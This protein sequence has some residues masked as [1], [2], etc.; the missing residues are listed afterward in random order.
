MVTLAN[1]LYE[2]YNPAS[3][4]IDKSTGPFIRIG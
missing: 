1:E 3:N 4:T 2:K